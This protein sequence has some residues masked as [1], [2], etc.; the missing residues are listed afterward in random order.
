V[1]YDPRLVNRA[2]WNERAP[3]HAASDDYG[4][5][6]FASDPSYLS[7][8]VTFD[9][10]RLGPV[11]GLRG[12]H[13]QCHIGTDTISLARLGA[14]M[15]GLDFSAA[16]LAEARR[17]AAIARAEVDFHEADAE[18]GPDGRL[19]VEDPYF[20]RAEPTAVVQHGTYVE[21]PT[22]FSQNV[23]YQWNHA[24]E[25]WSRRSWIRAWSSPRSASTTAFPG[26]RCPARWNE[27]SSANGACDS[28]R[29]VLPSRTR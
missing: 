25:R 29:F 1:S 20:E 2:H 21:T 11:A 8:V 10:P 4:F 9:L 26:K 15:S 14:R 17:L 7:G 28:A 23:T 22:E 3:A 19:A 18:V 27:S 5:N 13:L 24:S 6:R 16:S 12:V